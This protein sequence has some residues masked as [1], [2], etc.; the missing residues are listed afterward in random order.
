MVDSFSVAS[1]LLPE[2][3][4]V[5]AI[6][7]S[8]ALSTLY[9]FET[10][11]FL[12]DSAFDM[13]AALGAAATLSNREDGRPY[14]FH[15]VLATLETV[16]DL[17]QGAVYRAVLVPRLWQL[18]LTRHSRV[19][20]DESV[21]AILQT[22]LQASGLTAED[23]TLS[24]AGS[25]PKKPHVCQVRESNF[26]FLSRRMEREGMY[27]FFEQGEDRER[28]VITDD[29]SFHRPLVPDPVRYFQV[30][31]AGASGVQGLRSFTSRHTSVPGAVRVRDYDYLRPA[32]DV[33]GRA[34]V[35][36]RAEEVH[37]HEETLGTPEEGER[38]AR[39]RAE[40]LSA[41]KVVFRGSGRV[42]FLRPG[43]TF[44]VEDHPRPGVDGEY[45]TTELAHTGNQLG[46]LVEAKALL[47]LEEEQDDV[48]HVDVVAI[49]SSVQF[50]PERRTRSRASTGPRAP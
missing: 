26:A 45:L 3:A 28:L 47:G 23:Y 19:F 24:L 49:P 43:C 35:S 6:R 16:S 17:A 20:V 10:F 50:R 1:P 39:V 13:A 14:L 11:L 2:G 37:F 15:G 42:F 9:R 7:G 29:R 21:P 25:Y 36:A 41:R 38:I 34:S 44:D 4:R 40:E 31:G 18:T 33:S 30:A 5:L 8:E 12:D 22:V 27:Y 48:Y 46:G 32:L